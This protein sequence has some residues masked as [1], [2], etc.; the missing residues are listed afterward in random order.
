MNRFAQMLVAVIVAVAVFMLL[1][2]V[3]MS[4]PAACAYTATFIGLR[5]FFGGLLL[6]R[7]WQTLS[8]GVLCFSSV[9]AAAYLGAI[10]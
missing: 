1:L 10:K 3:F 8:G 7:Q 5:G 6:E 9:V 4:L 2:A